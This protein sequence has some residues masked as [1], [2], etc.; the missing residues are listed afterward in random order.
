MKKVIAILMVLAIVA[1]AAFATDPEVNTGLK[2]IV[3]TSTVD[4]II[5]QFVFKGTMNSDYSTEAVSVTDTT[6][7]ELDSELSIAD[8]D[9]QAYFIILQ[10]A[11]KDKD[12]NASDYARYN[13]NISFAFAI[14]DLIEQNPGENRTAKQVAGNLV[15]NSAVAAE[16]GTYTGSQANESKTLTNAITNTLDGLTFTAKYNGRVDNGQEIGRFSAIWYKDSSL[17]NG[18]YKADITVTITVEN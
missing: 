8:S 13:K 5:P 10:N 7:T 6:A 18:E 16:A 17:P 1:G 4:E 11:A 9:I 3:L 12:N 2:K 14:G 15:A